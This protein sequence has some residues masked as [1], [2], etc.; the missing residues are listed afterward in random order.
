MREQLVRRLV[1]FNFSA[2]SYPRFTLGGLE[3]RDLELLGG[4]ISRLIDGKVVAPDEPWIREYL[5]LPAA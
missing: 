5:G 1:D 2:G 4:L 3:E